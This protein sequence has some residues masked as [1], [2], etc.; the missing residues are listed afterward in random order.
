M[1]LCQISVPFNAG[2]AFGRGLGD[3]LNALYNYKLYEMRAWHEN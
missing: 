1:E 2:T 3:S